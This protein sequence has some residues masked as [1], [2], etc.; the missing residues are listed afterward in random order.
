MFCRIFLW[1]II[2]VCLKLCLLPRPFS[3]WIFENL[4]LS[5]PPFPRYLGA[6]WHSKIIFP[7]EKP[8]KIS[9][10]RNWKSSIQEPSS[11]QALKLV[12]TWS[13]QSNLWD[14]LPQTKPVYRLGLALVSPQP[15]L[16]ALSWELQL[17]SN[18]LPTQPVGYLPH[19]NLTTLQVRP[20]KPPIS[21]IP[22]LPHPA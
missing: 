18:Q 7:E 10:E 6:R 19:P 4:V 5:L 14:I 20:R 13:W 21:I 8:F 1:T 15:F 11:P 3:F 12:K 22:I 16:Q 2:E 9:E 17:C